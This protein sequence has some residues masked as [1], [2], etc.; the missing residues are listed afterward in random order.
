MLIVVIV[1]LAVVVLAVAGWLVVGL[2]LKLLWWALVGLV[3]G[4]L[5]RLILPGK[6]EISL[7]GTVG[8]GVAA[9][10]LGGIVAHALDLGG[11]LQFVI[12]LVL[13]VALVAALSRTRLARA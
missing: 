3:V 7:L 12:A 11:L 13:A 8:A 1:L 10:L 9:A 4:A 2:A 6:Q 5:A